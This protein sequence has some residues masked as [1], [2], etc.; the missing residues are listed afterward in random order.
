M[1]RS[2]GEDSG[3]RKVIADIAKFGWH[4]VHIHGEGDIV[5][6]TFT[7]GL[8]QTCQH[9]ELIIFG[10]PSKV[11][12]QILTIAADAAKSGEPLELSQTT[13]SLLE[14]YP[15]CFAEVP[16]TEYREYVGYARWYYEGDGF[17]LYQIVWPARS[18]QF[19]WDQLASAEFK[20][21]QPVIGHVVGNN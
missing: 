21:A 11:S 5:E 7:V 10:I 13:Q 16:R 4:C 20:R 15:C 2:A 8:F 17:P 3:E 19:P 9:P 1:V 12:H 6:Y 18:G 14:G